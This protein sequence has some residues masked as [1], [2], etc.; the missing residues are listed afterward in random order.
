MKEVRRRQKI[1][2]EDCDSFLMWKAFWKTFRENP[3]AFILQTFALAAFFL[4]LLLSIFL[5]DEFVNASP[6]V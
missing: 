3:L 4:L 5:L 1:T 6:A 2:R